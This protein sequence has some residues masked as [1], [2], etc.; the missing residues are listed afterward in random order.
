MTNPEPT[1]RDLGDDDLTA[2]GLELGKISTQVP[3][4]QASAWAARWALRAANE[5]ERRAGLSPD[6]LPAIVMLSDLGSR[7]LRHLRD[8]V[9]VVATLE[10]TDGDSPAARW[11]AALHARIVRVLD[12]RHSD[13]EPLRAWMSEHPI[14]HDTTGLPTW[15]EVSGPSDDA[16]LAP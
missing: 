7:E 6:P 2:T 8:R 12:T 14:T 13:A 11:W 15:R 9:H 10:A 5:L 16:G 3:Y 1:L 4:R